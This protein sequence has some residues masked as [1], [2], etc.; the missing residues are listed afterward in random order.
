M[1]REHCVKDVSIIAYVPPGLL[2]KYRINNEP[3]SGGERL[4]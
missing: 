3:V 1:D 2:A 4:S